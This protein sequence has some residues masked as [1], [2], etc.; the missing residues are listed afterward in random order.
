MGCPNNINN[1]GC[2][3]NPCGCKIS[4]DDIAY[5]GPNLNCSGIETCD[6]VSEA[7]NKL[8][9]YA[10]SIDMV[11]NIIY[12][13]TNN[14]ELYN[15]FITIVNQTVDCQTIFNCLATTTTTT[16]CACNNYSFE[17][18]EGVISSQE[19]AYF[20]CG[21][22]TALVTLTVDPGNTY[23]ACI[24]NANGITASN[25]VNITKLDCCTP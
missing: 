8:D 13:I 6:T 3:N 18:Q 4:S 24:Q 1:C 23:N 25:K 10:C 12:N 11:Q 5:Q 22:I 19:V 7:I 9:D 16:T 20:E 2:E 17:T 15:Q 14:I 21:N